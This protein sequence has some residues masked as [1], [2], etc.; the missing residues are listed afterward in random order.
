M[1]ENAAVPVSSARKPPKRRRKGFRSFFRRTKNDERKRID[2]RRRKRT[3]VALQHVPMNISS[4]FNLLEVQL[5]K[6]WLVSE[7]DD[8][9]IVQ[10]C[11]MKSSPPQVARSITVQADFS[12]YAHVTGRVVPRSNQTI[13]QL[14]QK[15]ADETTLITVVSAIESARICPGNPEERFT[16]LLEKRG[17]SVQG[18]GGQVTAFLDSRDEVVSGGLA[19]S[20]TVRR[21]DCEMLCSPDAAY[22]KR[23]Q[24]CKKYRSQLQVMCSRQQSKAASNRVS[25]NSHTNYRFLS[26]AEKDKRLHNLEKAK[27]AE[28]KQKKRLS[29]K[30]NEL[31]EQDGVTLIDEDVEDISSIFDS[32]ASDVK[33]NFKEFSVQKIFWDQQQHHFSLKNKKSMKWHPLL[34][35]FALNLKYA[36]SSAYRIVRESGL[37]ALPSERTLRDYTHWVTMKDGV[38]I[39]VIQQ[40][41]KAIG[42]DEMEESKKHF[43]LSMDEMKIRSGLVF[44]K[45]TGELTGFCNL[46]GVN[47]D[48][49]RL[50]DSLT[51]QQDLTPAL[52]EQMLVF[53]VRPIFKPSFSFPVAMYPSTALKGEKLYPVV[54]EVIEALELHG[55]QQDSLTSDGNS[56]NRRFYSLCGL[57]DDKPIYKTKNPYAD[58]QLYFMCD[59]PHLLKTARN[60]LSNSYAH[61]KSRMLQV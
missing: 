15:V 9:G 43:A 57:T 10:F 17:G 55:I 41:K 45:E 33:K 3:C 35:R 48:L 50:F 26:S 1:S 60:C 11:L 24:C 39:E 49:E 20:R 19:Y 32:V 28:C 31:I 4:P 30:I 36:S 58:R 23:C 38:Q 16:Q 21:W 61:S 25:H 40:L 56:P 14:P 12:W 47:Q 37:I 27:I 51:A 29:E 42:F 54:W 13:Q 53:M 5:P 34:I 18:I 46:G 44:K 59:P 6:G 52:A 2:E 8:G 7:G 22:L